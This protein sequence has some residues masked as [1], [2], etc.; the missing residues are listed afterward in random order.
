MET[1]SAGRNHK[2]REK[3]MQVEYIENREDCKLE[4]YRWETNT[5]GRNKTRARIQMV[6]AEKPGEYCRVGH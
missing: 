4:T 1:N 2:K 3:R 5:C 6:E